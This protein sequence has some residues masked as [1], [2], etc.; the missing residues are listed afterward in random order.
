[1]MN[2]R[3][4]LEARVCETDLLTR[5]EDC[6]RR[7]GK[8]CSEGRPPKMSIP[9][10]HTDDDFFICTTLR[11]AIHYYK[12]VEGSTAIPS[13]DAA[14]ALAQQFHEAYERL[15]PSFGYATRQESAKPWDDV[16]VANRQLIEEVCREVMLPKL[17]QAKRDG[18]EEAAVI[19]E[20]E[21]IGD[22][23]AD[24]HDFND[25][26]RLNNRVLIDVAAEIRQR[27]TELA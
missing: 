11:D 20:G 2:K 4:K 24:R 17:L 12:T 6:Q 19:V 13:P 21:C 22:V 23:V 14:K 27:A 16:P 3:E 18:M 9:V 26:E 7:I 1:M 10:Q 25:E 5:L 15:A 8:M